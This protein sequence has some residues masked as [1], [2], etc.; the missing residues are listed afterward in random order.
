MHLGHVTCLTSP[1]SWL[2]VKMLRTDTGFVGRMLDP[3]RLPYSDDLCIQTG[4]SWNVETA[5]MYARDQAPQGDQYAPNV[6][7]F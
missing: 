1:S 2:F 7:L 5:H 6:S 4:S 3:T